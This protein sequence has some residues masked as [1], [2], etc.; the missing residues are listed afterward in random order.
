MGFKLYLSWFPVFWGTCPGMGGRTAVW[1]G[2]MEETKYDKMPGPRFSIRPFWWDIY[3]FYPYDWCYMISGVIILSIYIYHLK[4]SHQVL[5][6]VISSTCR[7]HESPT[8]PCRFQHNLRC[9]STRDIPG[10]SGQSTSDPR[11]LLL[12][13]IASCCFWKIP[14]D[15]FQQ[16]STTIN[17]VCLILDDF[18]MILAIFKAFNHL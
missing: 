3:I 9:V 6:S 2:H 13:H 17:N 1:P 8:N 18:T 11:L 4:M 16:A 7:C 12:F 10:Q 14:W 15:M 5:M